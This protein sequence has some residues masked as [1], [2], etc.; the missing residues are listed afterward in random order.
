MMA[1]ARVA[2]ITQILFLRFFPLVF[3]NLCFQVRLFFF[4][5]EHFFFFLGRTLFFVFIALS[6]LHQ[7]SII[8][9]FLLHC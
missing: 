7:I 6:T 4:L 3:E 5:S 9:K 2:S 1:N 8:A